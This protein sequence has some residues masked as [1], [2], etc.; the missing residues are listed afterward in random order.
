MKKFI[1]LF[2]A[3]LI[4]FSVSIA[5]G[6]DGEGN[7]ETI[8]NVTDAEFSKTTSKGIVL[9]D[10]W[11]SWCRPCLMQGKIFKEMKD[12]IK[13]IATIAKVDIDR[14]KNSANKYYVRSIPTMILFKDGKVIK[15]YVGVQT[16]EVLLRDIKAA[17]AN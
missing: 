1:A 16:K 7:S 6:N 14:N 4:G 12:D 11:A 15:R 5:G 2:T 17:A 8:I 3:L 13:G 9:V 10:F